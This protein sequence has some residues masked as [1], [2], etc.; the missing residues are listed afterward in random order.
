MYDMY[1]L[2]V[3]YVVRT[4][5]LY[6]L[7]ELYEPSVSPDPVPRAQSRRREPRSALYSNGQSHPTTLLRRHQ[8]R[9]ENY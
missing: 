4:Y 7:Y 2:Y 5:E 6:V 9:R 3:V 8:Q 1:V